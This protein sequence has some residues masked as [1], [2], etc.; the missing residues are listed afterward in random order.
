M[1][2]VLDE[3]RIQGRRLDGF[4]MEEE[5]EER[6]L[7]NEASGSTWSAGGL[8]GRRDE[9]VLD[10]GR[11]YWET[12][13]PT[14]KFLIRETA[15]QTASRVQVKGRSESRGPFVMSRV[16]GGGCT[17]FYKVGNREFSVSLG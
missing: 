3:R 2:G 1:G 8:S 17:I 11:T 14:D 10:A 5:V 15:D 9:E 6:E 13:K 12:L 4:V 16:S 7:E